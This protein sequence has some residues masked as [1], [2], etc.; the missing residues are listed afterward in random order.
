M[1]PSNEILKLGLLAFLKDSVITVAVL[2]RSYDRVNS[3]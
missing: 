1:V 2:E 3:V